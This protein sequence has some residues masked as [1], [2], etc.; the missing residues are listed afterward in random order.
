MAERMTNMQA[1][2]L[3]RAIRAGWPHQQ[4][5]DG[6]VDVWAQGL[7]HV[8]PPLR[9]EDCEEAINRLVTRASFSGPADI[10]EAVRRI[11]AAR[12]DE[13]HLATVTPNVEPKDTAAYQA[14]ILALEA[15]AADGRW[16][17]EFAKA[18]QE[19]GLTLSG[20]PA[21]KA[22]GSGRP[23]PDV[24]LRT[25]RDQQRRMARRRVPAPLPGN[26]TQP[27]TAPR[28]PVREYTP[29]ELAAQEAQ[30]AAALRAL[31]ERIKA[32]TASGVDHADA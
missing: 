20:A 21:C 32:E 30:R 17:A 31:E 26:W 13:A 2:L 11:R 28:A 3:A 7:R 12:V 14:E 16:T 18:Y 5:D 6:T 4:F 10:V 8:D 29:A 19:Q 27:Y 22:I 25:L 23:G 1:V 24:D 15:A 9:Y